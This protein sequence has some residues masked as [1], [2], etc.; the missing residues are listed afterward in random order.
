MISHHYYSD[1]VQLKQKNTGLING[2]QGF[3]RCDQI[4]LATKIGGVT[5]IQKLWVK[6]AVGSW[7]PAGTSIVLVR[8]EI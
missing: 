8:R 3:T 1:D 4:L 5:A 2:S 7:G 6:S